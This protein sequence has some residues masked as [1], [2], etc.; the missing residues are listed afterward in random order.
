M[1]FADSII[2]ILFSTLAVSYAWG[3]RGTVI[4]GEKGAM[5]PGALIGLI[6]AWFS[7]GAIREN[8]WFIA[9]AGLMGMTYGGTE[10]Y[11]ETIGMVLHRGKA[12]YRPI[13]GYTGLAFKGALWF[14]ICGGFIAISF[15]YGVYSTADIA[16][17]CLLIPLVQQIGYWIFN[18]PYDKKNGRYPKIFFSL[19]RREEWGSNF[20]LLIAM[21]TMAIIRNDSLALLM[22]AFG[23]LFGAFGWVV[24]MKCYVLSVFPLTNGKYIFG[25]LYHNN[26]IDGWKIMEFVLGA[27]GGF[28]LSLSF[29]IG[30]EYI[31]VY[32]TRAA[33]DGVKFFNERISEIA[34]FVCV[35]CAVG[36]FAVNLFAH[37]CDKKNKSF[38]SYVLDRIERIFYCVIPMIFVLR[39]EQYSSKFMTGFM[40]LFVLI[41]KLLFDRFK[42]V[43]AFTLLIS[44]AACALS[45]FILVLN[46]ITP[47]KIIIAGTVPYL[48]GELLCTVVRAK[49]EGISLKDKLI[50]TPFITVYPCLV[51]QSIII[52]FVSWKIFDI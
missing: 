2:C 30:Y 21:I 49:N 31:D 20:A 10:P 46:G 47:L 15:S 26:R 33:I 44:F 45:Y 34:P 14:S 38:N 11:G 25:K 48:V 51:I 50:G 9:A 5:L 27:F 17:F 1:N 22:I 43:N 8:W 12:D 4:G 13:K 19:T 24:A 16:V 39:G 37:I 6:L 18:T 23:F 42:K 40:L 36:I 28:G 35:L 7:G 3:M 32:K 29:C 52:I 41:I